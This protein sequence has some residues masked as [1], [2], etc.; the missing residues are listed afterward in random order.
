MTAPPS[1]LDALTPPGTVPGPGHRATIAC[2]GCGRRVLRHRAVFGYGEECADQRG[3][4]V[5]RWHL[6][7]TPPPDAPTL[8]DQLLEEPMPLGPSPLDRPTRLLWPQPRLH[9]DAWTELRAWLA[10]H[11]VTP[12]DPIDIV[13]G[14]SHLLTWKTPGWEITALTSH[15]STSL[16]TALATADGLRCTAHRGTAG[17]RNRWCDRTVDDRG[18][19]D[20]DHQ[21]GGATWGNDTDDTL[22]LTGLTPRPSTIGE[23]A[24]LDLPDRASMTP[25]SGPAPSHN[26]LRA[27][28]DAAAPVCAGRGHTDPVYT[29]IRACSDCAAEAVLSLIG[30]AR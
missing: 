27:A 22:D 1:L 16:L 12:G 13:I 2:I 9:T 15:P 7:T 10:T 29:P 19:H 4:T 14:P 23:R 24:Q 8:F 20:G 6:T 11:H 25:R 28:I 5:R 21:R 3:L 26:A 18:Y 17:G 30:A